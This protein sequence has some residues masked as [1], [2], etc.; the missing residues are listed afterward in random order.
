LDAKHPECTSFVA[1]ELISLLELCRCFQH[2][3]RIST[4][5]Q[6][7]ENQNKQEEISP[8]SKNGAGATLVIERS[9]RN[10]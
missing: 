2:T 7:R 3:K 10:V 1:H 9:A 5:N 8:I 4:C 6:Y